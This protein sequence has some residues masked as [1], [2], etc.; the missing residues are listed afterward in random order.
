VACKQDRLGPLQEHRLDT[1]KILLARGADPFLVS[2]YG[3][4]V[5]Q[6]ACIKVL[7]LRIIG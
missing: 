2:K 7:C 4:D 1:A 3:D 5:L 6:T